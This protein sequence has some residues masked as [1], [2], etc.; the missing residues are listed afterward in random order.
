MAKVIDYC[1]A[2]ASTPDTLVM[3]VAELIK[4]GWQPM[5]GV[6]MT[7][8]SRD[9]PH[10]RIA[11]AMVKH[12]PEPEVTLTR[13]GRTIFSCEPSGTPKPVGWKTIVCESRWRQCPAVYGYRAGWW[14]PSTSDT[15]LENVST[16]APAGVILLDGEGYVAITG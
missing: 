9:F 16:M 10:S 3:V 15:G 14:P 5:G 2:H 13:L 11:Q 12:E 1:V 6:S 8:P 7:P 4:E